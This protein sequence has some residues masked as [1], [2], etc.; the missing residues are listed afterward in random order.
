MEFEDEE[1]KS[2]PT[3]NQCSTS[4]WTHMQNIESSVEEKQKFEIDFPVER[5]SQDA[6]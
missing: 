5:V 6:I 3:D 1:I 2:N 4:N